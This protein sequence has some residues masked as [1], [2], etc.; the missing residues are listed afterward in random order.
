MQI[1][2]EILLLSTSIYSLRKCISYRVTCREPVY[3]ELRGS[4]R[5]SS[6]YLWRCLTT[7]YQTPWLEA[8]I[9]YAKVPSVGFIRTIVPTL[10]DIRIEK[11]GS[12]VHVQSLRDQSS[13]TSSKA[14]D[15]LT[16]ICF[17]SLLP[18]DS[19]R[20]QYSVISF[21][22]KLNGQSIARDV[23]RVVKPA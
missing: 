3:V 21:A 17:S 4:S 5:P 18:W 19:I 1:V 8:C 15:S 9:R 22:N 2:S 10:S 13:N 12:F 11:Y 6:S 16:Y 7:S 20:S 14:T 23:Q